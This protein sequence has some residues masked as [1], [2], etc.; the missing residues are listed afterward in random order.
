MHGSKV[1]LRSHNSRHKIGE[2]YSKR[3]N[4]EDLLLERSK[5]GWQTD[6]CGGQRW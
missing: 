2:A 1:S 3:I 4:P 6:R 5:C